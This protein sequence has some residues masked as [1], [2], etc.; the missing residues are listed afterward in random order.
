MQP[1]YYRHPLAIHPCAKSTG[2]SCLSSKLWMEFMYFNAEIEPVDTS[3]DNV[4]TQVE[5]HLKNKI[6]ADESLVLV[7][8]DDNKAIGYSI[9]EI[10]QKLAASR[11]QTLGIIY[12]MAITAGHRRKGI[13]I[14]MLERIKAWF[15]K[16]GIKRIEISAVTK[17]PSVIHSGKNKVFRTPNRLCI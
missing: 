13:G 4:L 6:T 5:T 16:R 11:K 7:A 15:K 12:D 8:I 2:G 3:G 9:S 14:A 17:K 10:T 1:L